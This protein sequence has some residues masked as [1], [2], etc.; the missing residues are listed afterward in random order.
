LRGKWWSL[1]HGLK[2][3]ER[4]TWNRPAFRWVQMNL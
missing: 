1:P 3:V 2:A 4:F